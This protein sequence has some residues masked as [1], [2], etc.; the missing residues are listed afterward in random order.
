MCLEYSFAY[1]VRRVQRYPHIPAWEQKKPY[2]SLGALNV[3]SVSE[4]F[5]VCTRILYPVT[6]SVP[7]RLE[8]PGRLGRSKQR[9]V[10]ALFVTGYNKR[11]HMYP[12]HG[13]LRTLSDHAGNNTVY[14]GTSDT[15][16]GKLPWVPESFTKFSRPL[17]RADGSTL[18]T[19]VITSTAR[20]IKQRVT[21][22]HR[23]FRLLS[24]NST[25]GKDE[26]ALPPPPPAV[27][28]M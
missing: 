19:V 5:A 11:V 15:I 3:R 26:I 14:P 22:E 2:D 7:G 24:P 12:H 28:A 27:K 16:L 8:R 13:T 9:Y 20:S 23:Q 21:P 1:W 25:L 18:H 4:Q 10:G 17:V 6:N